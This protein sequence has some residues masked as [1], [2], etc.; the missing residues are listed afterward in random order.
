MTL[1]ERRYLASLPGERRNREENVAPPR[2]TSVGQGFTVRSYPKSICIGSRA[3]CSLLLQDHF[4]LDLMVLK[5]GWAALA[6][7]FAL[8]SCPE[9]VKNLLVQ[10][11]S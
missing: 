7:M 8:D 11:S 4:A 9:G 6:L 3:N 10:T 2:V 1:S 5:C